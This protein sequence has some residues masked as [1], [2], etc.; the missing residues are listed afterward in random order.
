MNCFEN[1]SGAE[2]ITLA[3]VIAIFL[4]QNLSLDD[5][6]VLAVFFS[7]LGDNLAAIGVVDSLPSASTPST[8][9]EINPTF[10]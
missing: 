3:N 5:I 9:Q 4:S 7:C 6:N 1:I 8:L 10:L 2:L